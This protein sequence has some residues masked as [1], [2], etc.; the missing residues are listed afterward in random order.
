[1]RRHWYIY[2]D[3]V[4]RGTTMAIIM[5]ALIAGLRA[6]NPWLFLAFVLPSLGIQVW[7]NRLV[8]LWELG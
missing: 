7:L 3:A 4:I 6:G 2:L 5:F 1:M 8:I